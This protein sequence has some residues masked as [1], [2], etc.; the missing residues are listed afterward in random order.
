MR[1]TRP[2][3]EKASCAAGRPGTPAFN[4]MNLEGAY[5]PRQPHRLKPV[6]LV[7]KRNQTLRSLDVSLIAL[8][9]RLDQSAFLDVAAIE[10]SEHDG[11]GKE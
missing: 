10:K 7:D 3:L 6:F 9:E 8:A 1:L 4:S 5:N 2:G 11:Q